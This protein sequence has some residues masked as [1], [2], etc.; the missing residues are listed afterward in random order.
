MSR[1]APE[2]QRVESMPGEE[3]ADCESAW[4]AALPDLAESL[5]EVIR[6]LTAEG[7]LAEKDGRLVLAR[8]G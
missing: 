2:I 7:Y 1:P 8:K 5:A 6:R 3:F 4:R